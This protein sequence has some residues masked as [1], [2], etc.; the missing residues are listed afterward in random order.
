MNNGFKLL[1]VITIVVIVFLLS[2]CFTKF[3]ETT[4]IDKVVRME[5]VN[6]YKSSKYLIFCENEVFENTDSFVYLKFNSSD[7]MV[8]IKEGD[9]Y[10]FTVTGI[11]LP[12]LSWYRNIVKVEKYDN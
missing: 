2:F 9:V 7:F 3:T 4:T 11:R 5:R 6:N 12:F 8:M 1:G 10:R